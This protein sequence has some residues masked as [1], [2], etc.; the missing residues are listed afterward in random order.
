[1]FIREH[2]FAS[3]SFA[4]VREAFSYAYP[5]KEVPNKTTVRRVV[6]ELRHAGSVCD[7]KY[8]RRRKCV[9]AVKLF[10]KFSVTNKIFENNSFVL[11]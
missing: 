11:S 9:S 2:C 4:A 5:H 6:T 7:R 8:I 3:K 1:V 10:C